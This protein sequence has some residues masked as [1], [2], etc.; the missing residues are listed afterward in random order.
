MA[1]TRNSA[2]FLKL[3]QLGT[4]GPGKSPDFIVL[5]AVPLDNIAKPKKAEVCCV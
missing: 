4:V 1:A 2:E 3:D 5:D